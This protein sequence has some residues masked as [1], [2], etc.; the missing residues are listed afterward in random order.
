MVYPEQYSAWLTAL[1]SSLCRRFLGL[2]ALHGL[3][4]L[5][6]KALSWTGF[7]GVVALP[8]TWHRGRALMA[9]GSACMCGSCPF[10]RAQ[11]R[12]QSC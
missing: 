6:L 5:L 7:L 12:A 11:V 2:G 9:A 3:R 4:L 1:C 10:P 8:L